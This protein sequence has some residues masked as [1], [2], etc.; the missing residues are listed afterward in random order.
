M[1]KSKRNYNSRKNGARNSQKNN[2]QDKAM[3]R[4]L[5]RGEDKVYALEGR[6]KGSND[7]SWY[8]AS[9]TMLNNVAQIPFATWVGSGIDYPSQAEDDYYINGTNA[10]IMR[11]DILHTLGRTKTSVDPINVAGSTLYAAIQSGNSRTPG[12]EMA[13]LMLYIVAMSDAYAYY[14]YLVRTYGLMSN[15]QIL[16]K[17]TPKAL[18]T[19]MGL[20]Y[21]NLQGQLANFRTFINQ[22]AYKLASFYL[23]KDITYVDRRIFMYE[24]IYMDSSTKKAQWYYFQPAG[25][26]KWVEGESTQALTYLQMVTAPMSQTQTLA[27]LQDLI[28]FGDTLMEPLRWSEDIR[29]MSADLLKVF[30]EGGAFTIHPIADTYTVTPVYEPEVAMQIEN[31]RIFPSVAYQGVGS[32]NNP[33]ATTQITQTTGIN[34]GFLTSNYSYA[35]YQHDWYPTSGDLFAAWSAAIPSDGDIINMHSE[36]VTPEDIMVA[37]RLHP[38]GLPTLS[39]GGD[40]NTISLSSCYFGTEV[41]VGAFIYGLTD[42]DLIQVSPSGFYTANSGIQPVNAIEH[43]TFAQYYEEQNRGFTANFAAIYSRFDWAPLI[44]F[45]C[46]KRG[47]VTNYTYS[48][49][50]LGDLDNWT[51]MP[52]STIK[53]LHYNALLGEF[54]CRF[55]SSYAKLK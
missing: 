7:P 44:Y 33:F 26:Y 14:A 43:L 37:T 4:E 25:F 16:N 42:G 1:S 30:G 39:I 31:M 11:I 41:P 54:E 19:S 36:N 45:L 52:I 3:E 18:I 50:L 51:Y 32:V 6:G 13:D 23:P 40:V 8:V 15:F 28:D 55:T 9:N 22:Y 2:Y 20:D 29:M 35:T 53:E 38:S 24:N 27:T 34:E 46:E 48:G 17:Y 5:K 10:G 12:Y 21:P 49:A 47:D